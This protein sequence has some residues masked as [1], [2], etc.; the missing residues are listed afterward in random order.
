VIVPVKGPQARWVI[1][2]VGAILVVS[3]VWSQF[4]VR[5]EVAQALRSHCEGASLRVSQRWSGGLFDTEK[6]SERSV[7]VCLRTMKSYEIRASNSTAPLVTGGTSWWPVL[8]LVLALAWLSRK[9]WLMGRPSA[10]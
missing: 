4:N 6:W 8:W 9:L 2:V 7:F 5:A 1:G 3:F 10:T